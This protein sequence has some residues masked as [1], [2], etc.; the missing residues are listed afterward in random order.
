MNTANTILEQIRAQDP[1]AIW[2]WGAKDFVNMGNGLKFRTS[3]LTP[4]K[5]HIYIRYNAGQDLYDVQFYRLKRNM[6]IQVD[7]EVESVYADQLVEVIDGF[8]G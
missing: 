2:A 1:K 3:G 8:V 7:K 4:W 6:E 5:G